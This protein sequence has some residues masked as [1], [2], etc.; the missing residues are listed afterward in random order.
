MLMLPILSGKQIMNW[1]ERFVPCGQIRR[2]LLP[3]REPLF[4]GQNLAEYY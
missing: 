4:C 1:A 2:E 3:F